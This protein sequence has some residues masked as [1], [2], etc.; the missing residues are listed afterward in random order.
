MVEG[1]KRCH[2]LVVMCLL[3][4]A[5]TPA[6]AFADD[7]TGGG[8]GSHNFGGSYPAFGT[9]WYGPEPTSNLVGTK[10]YQYGVVAYTQYD[11]AVYNLVSGGGYFDTDWENISAIKKNKLLSNADF[12]DYANLFHVGKPDLDPSL[13]FNTD[14]AVVSAWN[15]AC[16]LY[17]ETYCFSA[18]YTDAQKTAAHRALRTILL[19]EDT[20]PDQTA[21]DAFTYNDRTYIPLLQWD[22]G[23]SYSNLNTIGITTSRFITI[24]NYADSHD[25]QLY[26]L[27]L[28]GGVYTSARPADQ[29][30]YVTFWLICMDPDNVIWNDDHSL[31]FEE[32][33]DTMI[34][35][36]E[37][38]KDRVQ[39]QYSTATVPGHGEF[40]YWS[41][42]SN[43]FTWHVQP[44]AF[45]DHAAGTDSDGNQN[46]WELKPIYFTSVIGGNSNVTDPE[47]DPPTWPTPPV[48]PTPPT[49]P[50][51]PT[52]DPPDPPTPYEPTEPKP[53]NPWIPIP[54]EDVTITGENFQDLLDALNEHCIHLQNSIQAN[55]QQ[56]WNLQSDL[57]TEQFSTLDENMNTGI[58]WLGNDVIFASFA[59]LK[60]YLQQ[61]FEWLSEKL[62]FNVTVNGNDPYDD[63][64]LLYWIK[65]IWA[66][67]PTGINTRPTDPITNPTGWWDWLTQLLNNL[68]ADLMMLGHDKLAGVLEMLNQLR[69]KFPFSL[70][71]DIAT[72]L[73]LLVAVPE[74]PEFDVPAYALGS[75][76]E[77][78][79]VGSYHITLEPYEQVWEGVKWIETLAFAV[80]LITHT[81]GLMDMAQ[82]TV[83]PR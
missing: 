4:L 68:A 6:V 83:R 32:G 2:L 73:G 19:E 56:L 25:M 53:Y 82:K 30:K 64:G 22:D 52:P 43:P 38:L 61:L 5:I 9:V 50:P 75:N 39:Y 74:C 58:Q 67:L 57:L 47:P 65:Q 41:I 51:V 55:V 13:I 44:G 16:Q 79:E 8:G 49:D 3:L 34:A 54:G 60:D 26:G 70:P 27:I 12:R 11:A 28:N 17:G 10:Y 63:T 80:Y 31:S 15:N 18:M 76:M 24:K 36:S 69:N 62:N 45:R 7:S 23:W 33:F 37:A 78:S 48:D 59:D 77:L 46:W 71:W 40:K 1:V 14:Y 21:E 29:P 81:S 35:K 66:K 20:T 42:N 72:L